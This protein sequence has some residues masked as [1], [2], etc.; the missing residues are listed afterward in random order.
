MKQDGNNYT[1]ENTAK[2]DVKTFITRLKVIT[3][4]DEVIT[5]LRKKSEAFTNKMS[6]MAEK[7]LN[8]ILVDIIRLEVNVNKYIA[9]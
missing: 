3:H 8:C 1:S 4:A 5:A 9:I 6:Y 2:S 7:D